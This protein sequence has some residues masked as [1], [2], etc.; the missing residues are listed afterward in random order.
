MIKEQEII[1][2]SYSEFQRYIRGE[3]SRSEE[4]EF[5]RNLQEGPLSE[6]IIKGWFSGFALRKKTHGSV[7][8][9]GMSW[10]RTLFMGVTAGVM[11]LIL[12]FSALFILTGN[13]PDLDFLKR[14]IVTNS[15]QSSDPGGNTGINASVPANMT[16]SSSSDSQYRTGSFWD[17]ATASWIDKPE[18]AGDPVPSILKSSA[19]SGLLTAD[20]I[21]SVADSVSAPSVITGNTGNEP[22]S[23][24]SPSPVT[25]ISNFNRY[26]VENV[27]KPVSLTN[28]ES[29]TALVS[30]I[31]R[32][33][34]TLDS[35]RVIESP[36]AEFAREA[37]RL[38][39]EGPAWKPAVKN[40]SPID[41]VVKI[42][43][44]FK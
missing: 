31:V 5:Q 1:R 34:G 10:K 27:K 36:G 18:V 17:T 11:V 39:A 13:R 35:I 40:G 44:V 22:A 16:D 32:S 19:D 38:I 6:G 12:V 14:I 4:N 24:M 25:G 21:K 28:G 2:L 30:F 41:G 33:T 20:N 8:N 7:A 37:V 9:G 29:A 43:V 42:T 23:F 15:R 3:M 26:M